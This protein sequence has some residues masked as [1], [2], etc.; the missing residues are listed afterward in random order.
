MY[1]VH[2]VTYLSSLDRRFL[3]SVERGGLSHMT[4][5]PPLRRASRA[6]SPPHSW[7]RGRVPSLAAS[8]SSPPS[9]GGEVVC[10]ANR[11]GGRTSDRQLLQPGEAHGDVRAADIARR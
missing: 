9:S 8:A 6:T 7:G 5:V 2:S 1:P 3:S 4:K 11:S 10:E